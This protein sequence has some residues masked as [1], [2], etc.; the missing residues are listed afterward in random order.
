MKF[1][2]ENRNQIYTTEVSFP[3]YAGGF[4]YFCNELTLNTFQIKVLLET[5]DFNKTHQSFKIGFL[6]DRL[7]I[8]DMKVW[9]L[10]KYTEKDHE[11][12]YHIRGNS[13]NALPQVE[14]KVFPRTT[15]SQIDETLK[16]GFCVQEIF[17]P[18]NE[19]FDEFG[20]ILNLSK[21]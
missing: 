11:I 18:L 8:S 9:R 17:L 19:G 15:D 10:L 20:Q 14:S 4:Y 7:G 5:V 1:V 21:Y 3:I 13:N 6:T 2:Q 12:N 16:L